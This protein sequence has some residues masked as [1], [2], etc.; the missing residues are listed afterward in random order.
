MSKLCKYLKEDSSKQREQQGQVH[1]DQMDFQVQGRN[2]Q[3][4]AGRK[5]AHRREQGLDQEKSHGPQ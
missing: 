2:G 3:G 1:R 4:E 5:W